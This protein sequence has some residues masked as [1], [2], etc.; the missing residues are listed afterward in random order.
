MSLLC[1]CYD[2]GFSDD[3]R[4]SNDS[5]VIGF[6]LAR[7][8]DTGHEVFSKQAKTK[9][10]VGGRRWERV[11]TKGNK[12]ER[13]ANLFDFL[14]IMSESEMLDFQMGRTRS[15]VSLHVRVESRS[16]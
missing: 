6:R 1:I 12:G 14:S 11:R 13:G 16:S 8:F 2:V 3:V 15:C 7:V 4:L 9:G 10:A 5:I